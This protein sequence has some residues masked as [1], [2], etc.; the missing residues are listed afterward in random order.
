MSAVKMHQ[1]LLIIYKKPWFFLGLAGLV[2]VG[3]WLLQLKVKQPNP[4][5]T[6]IEAPSIYSIKNATFYIWQKGTQN[7]QL[8]IQH[9]WLDQEMQNARIANI[10]GV[11]KPNTDAT[12]YF[13]AE[14]A[15]FFFET[16]QLNL[17]KDVV[18][19]NQQ[20]QL[21]TQALGINLAE[22]KIYNQ[23]LTKIQ[24]S[25]LKGQSQGLVYDHQQQYLKLNQPKFITR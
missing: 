11:F 6:E 5:H 10:N 13:K 2:A 18:V 15:N 9:I 19:N 8:K 17:S 21:I 7:W 25:S 1:L 22:Q 4:T 3:F 24:N 20:M 23:Q 14:Q 16:Q 12:T